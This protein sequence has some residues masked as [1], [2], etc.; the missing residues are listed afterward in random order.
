[1]KHITR[2]CNLV[3]ALNGENVMPVLKE[4]DISVNKNIIIIGLKK[5]FYN[6]NKFLCCSG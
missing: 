3:T 4:I 6:V 2:L 1:M 5:L